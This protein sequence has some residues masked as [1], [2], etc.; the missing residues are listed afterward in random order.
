MKAV[1]K[2]NSYWGQFLRNQFI[3]RKGPIN[4]LGWKHLLSSCPLEALPDFIHKAKEKP[5]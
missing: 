3:K 5:L 1:I 2:I 4:V